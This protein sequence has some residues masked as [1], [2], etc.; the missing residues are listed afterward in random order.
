MAQFFRE[1]MLTD[2]KRK[3]PIAGASSERRRIISLSAVTHGVTISNFIHR[4]VLS[5]RFGFMQAQKSALLCT[6]LCL[7]FKGFHCDF[8]PIGSITFFPNVQICGKKP[9]ILIGFNISN[10]P[11]MLIFYTRR[12][13]GFCA[14]GISRVFLNNHKL[15]Q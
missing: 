2:G 13:S 12:P 9:Y 7:F 3:L 10:I 8:F 11:T 14:D 6:K 15:F 5:Q 4:Q 1:K